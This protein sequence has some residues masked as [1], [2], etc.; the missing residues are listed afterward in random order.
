MV[1]GSTAGYLGRISMCKGNRRQT[2]ESR[3]LVYCNVLAT[4]DVSIW[5]LKLS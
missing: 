3:C 5:M 2:G 4:V 1:D